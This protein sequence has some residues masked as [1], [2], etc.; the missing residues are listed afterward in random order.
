FYLWSISSK[1]SPAD[2]VLNWLTQEQ[3][4]AAHRLQ[5]WMTVSSTFLNKPIHVMLGVMGLFFNLVDYCRHH[6]LQAD[7]IGTKKALFLLSKE[8]RHRVMGLF[9]NLVHYCR[10]HGLQAKGD[11]GRDNG[12]AGARSQEGERN[13]RA[14]RLDVANH[15]WA[16]RRGLRGPVAMALK[17]LTCGVT[18]QRRRGIGA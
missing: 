17:Q 4:G 16:R 5:T 14:Y 18:C 3:G 6:G 2:T 15:A 11:L 13:S 8:H 7:F 1:S 9:F 10:H 12:F